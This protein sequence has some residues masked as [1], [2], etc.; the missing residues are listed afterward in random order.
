MTHPSGSGKQPDDSS[1]QPLRVKRGAFPTPQSEIEKSQPFI[2]D[3]NQA[4]DPDAEE[5]E[6]G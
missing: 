6:E 5:E 2:P 3:L 1:E 4:A